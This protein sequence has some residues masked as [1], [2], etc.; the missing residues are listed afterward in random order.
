MTICSKNATLKFL[1]PL[2]EKVCCSV[3]KLGSGGVGW[4]CGGGE[5]KFLTVGEVPER[6][7]ALN[8]KPQC[9]PL[10]GRA[11]LEKVSHCIS[12]KENPQP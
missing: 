7:E 6:P 9:M 12:Q 5:S 3:W 4:V 11:C 8:P 1:N 10:Y 2:V